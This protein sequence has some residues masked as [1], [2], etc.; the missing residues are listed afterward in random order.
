MTSQIYRVD[1]FIVPE[2]AQQEFL[3]KVRTTHALLRSLPGCTQELVLEQTSGPGSY[4][5][6]TVLGWSDLASI[7]AAKIEVQKLHAK[8]DFHPQVMFN[9]LGIQADLGNY[10]AIDIST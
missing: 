5:Y 1:K 4:N 10:Q 9:R 8:T 7:E 6:V 2:T 3:A